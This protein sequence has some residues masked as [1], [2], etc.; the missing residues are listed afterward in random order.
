[1]SES[2]FDKRPFFWGGIFIALMLFGAL[3]PWPYVY[4]RLLRLI[5][6]VASVFVVLVTYSLK[7]IWWTCIFGLI[8][9]LFNPL[10]PIHLSRE[11]WQ[12]IDVICAILFVVV[13]IVL[14]EPTNAKEGIS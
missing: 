5:V 14:R 9:L 11:I 7:Q 8:A 13:S 4:Y 3:A 6:C 2:F 10:I 12:P 1:M